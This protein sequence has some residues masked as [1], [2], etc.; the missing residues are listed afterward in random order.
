MPFLRRNFAVSPMRKKFNA[1]APYTNID[2]MKDGDIVHLQTGTEVTK[3][4]MMDAI[5]SARVIYV[6]E[7]H[8]NI[9]AHQAQLEII[10]EL[11]A[12]NPGKVAVGM[13]MFRR[14]AQ[15]ALDKL[16][17]GKMTKDELNALFDEQWTPDWREA[18]QP[19]LDFIQDNSIPLVGLKPTKEIEAVVRSGGTSPE[20][21][22]LDMDD[23]YHRGRYLP[24][25]SGPG[26]PP[27]AA[28]GRYK[29]MVLWD[30]AM[31]ETVADFLSNP[32]NADK[33]L[34]VIA[35]EGHI[36][37]GFG[38]PKRA[39]RRVP[40]DYSIVIPTI[41]QEPDADLPLKLG[42]YAM[43][44]PYDKLGMKPRP[45]ADPQKPKPPGK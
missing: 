19:V 17:Q 4:Q 39:Y 5:S 11:F 24:F 18:Y 29:M 26:I 34:V 9:A 45:A 37:Y 25:F 33:K 38:I 1:S 30:E 43:K 6:S 21:P 41:G 13:E 14:S 36:G 27:E 35:G 8:D 42:D 44:V 20:V 2:K 12:K 7:L 16:E 28:E 23:P 32:D 3:E 31:A 15:P 40:H 22:E 10:E